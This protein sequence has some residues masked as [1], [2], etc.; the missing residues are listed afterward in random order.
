MIR[1]APLSTD[2]VGRRPVV[3]GL[4][5]L[6]LQ[7]AELRHQQQFRHATAASCGER[8]GSAQC[9]P[10]MPRRNSSAAGDTRPIRREADRA[11]TVN[12]ARGLCK[13]PVCHRQGPERR[14]HDASGRRSPADR[15]AA[16]GQP[17]GK[18]YIG[19]DGDV[20]VAAGSRDRLVRRPGARSRAT[21]ILM[22]PTATATWC[23]CAARQA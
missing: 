9:P 17:D 7:H 12:T 13:S 22:P 23:T 10:N 5:R 2:G 19:P 11:R 6:Q 4:Q 21:S 8:R 14:R 20:G 3:G 18:N 15:T 1:A 16:Q